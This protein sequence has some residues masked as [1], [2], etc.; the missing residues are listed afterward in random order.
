MIEADRPSVSTILS[1]SVWEQKGRV[2]H[3]GK[4]IAGNYLQPHDSS[5]NKFPH[6]LIKIFL[7]T[8]DLVYAAF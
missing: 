2:S 3:L 8:L 6:I 5:F 1:S 7:L 4:P